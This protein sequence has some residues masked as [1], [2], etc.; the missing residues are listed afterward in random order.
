M[1]LPF[2][3][4]NLQMPQRQQFAFLNTWLFCH[5][6]EIIARMPKIESNGTTEKVRRMN[7]EG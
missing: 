7:Y 2:G 3:S 6:Y 5:S 1:S 4:L